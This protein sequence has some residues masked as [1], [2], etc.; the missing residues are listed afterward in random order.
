MLAFAFALLTAQIEGAPGVVTTPLELEE[1]RVAFLAGDLVTLERGQAI[2]RDRGVDVDHA[3]HGLLRDLARLVRCLPI[4]P[5]PAPS[6]ET[7]SLL[8]ARTLVRLERVRLERMLKESSYPQSLLA[9]LLPEPKLYLER[10]PPQKLELVRWPVEDERWAGEVVEGR[11]EAGKCPTR[12][13][14]FREAD[15][16]SR[17]ANQKLRAAAERAATTAVLPMLPSLPDA[18]AGKIALAYLQ[19]AVKAESFK[20]PLEWADRLEAGLRR[21]QPAIR[22]AGLV[23]LARARE[24]NGDLAG[25][26]ALYRELISDPSLT[27]EEDSRVRVRLTALEE[28]D[29]P[30]VRDVAAGARSPRDLDERVLSYAQARALYA[31]HDFDTLTTFGRVWLRKVRG[32]NQFDDAARDLF[33]K[34]AVELEPARAMSWIEEIGEDA[35][36]RERLDLLGQLALESD[37]LPLATAIY[38]RLRLLAASERK[39]RGPAAAAE[40]AHWIAQR[41]LVEFAAEDAEAFAAFM[42]QL[43]ALAFEQTDKPIARWAPHREVARLALDL[44]GRLTNEVDAKADRRKFAALLLEASVKL[45]AKPSRFQALLEER[46]PPLRVLAGP[47]AVGRDAAGKDAQATKATPDAR[48]TAKGARGKERKVRQLGEV[49]V[50]R[51]PPRIEAPDVETAVP[52]IDTFLVYEDERGALLSGVPW[53]ALAAERKERRAA[54]AVEAA[55]RKRNAERQET[56]ENE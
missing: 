19:D 49:V 43:V 41:A 2:L 34:L 15:G 53:A 52:A 14:A 45:T 56:E 24:Q 9:E 25:A 5:I 37:N 6:S 55:I 51:L 7:P 42:D 8:A 46:I 47:Y 31:L 1:L 54:A 39:K 17:D 21:G 13:G 29:W 44:I 48:K 26:T 22:S 27:N 36:L 30:R 23:M 35:R 20:F 18:A 32:G 16:K 11:V 4:G 10:A 12:P 50:P 3:S 33:L 40:E 28:P 38:D